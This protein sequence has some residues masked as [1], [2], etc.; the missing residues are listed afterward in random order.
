MTD[1]ENRRATVVDGVVRVL[2]DSHALVDW[3]D[4]DLWVGQGRL[5]ATMPYLFEHQC[6]QCQT[7]TLL[8]SRQMLDKFRGGELA[9]D[10]CRRSLAP[11]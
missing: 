5:T 2:L 6:T 4:E 9:C 3:H 7:R 10:A 1:L 11:Q 8:T